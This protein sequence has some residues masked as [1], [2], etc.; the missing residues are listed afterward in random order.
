[1]NEC[2]VISSSNRKR[3]YSVCYTHTGDS[4]GSETREY[5]C[6]KMKYGTKSVGKQKM[7]P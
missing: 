2:R 3:K 6:E 4:P 5:M 7:K 1:M